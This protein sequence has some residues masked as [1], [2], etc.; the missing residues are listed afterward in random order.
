VKLFVMVAVAQDGL[1]DAR[2]YP[3][4]CHDTGF[5][6]DSLTQIVRMGCGILHL[7]IYTCP[8]KMR[9]ISPY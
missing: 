1:P 2:R 6:E 4:W 9:I 3:F 5:V 8:K 7:A